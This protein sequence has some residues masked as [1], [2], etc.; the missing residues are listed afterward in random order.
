MPAI[1]I[2]G[3]LH[4]AE[5]RYA[6]QA[7]PSAGFDLPPHPKTVIA[8]ITSLDGPGGV[9]R[10]H[11]RTPADGP[12]YTKVTSRTHQ[13]L[14]DY[15]LA[16]MIAAVGFDKPAL[17]ALTPNLCDDEFEHY[18]ESGTPSV[19]AS[20]RTLAEAEE[21][22]RSGAVSREA[23]ESVGLDDHEGRMDAHGE[24]I[25]SI[26]ESDLEA[27]IDEHAMQVAF[28]LAIA[29]DSAAPPSGLDLSEPTYR[30]AVHRRDFADAAVKTA[31]RALDDDPTIEQINRLDAALGKVEAAEY[32][33]GLL[34]DPRVLDNLDPQRPGHLSVANTRAV[35]EHI[36]HTP[37]HG[38]GGGMLEP[39]LREN[40]I[41][42]LRAL[43]LTTF[44]K[45]SAETM[46]DSSSRHVART[47]GLAVGFGEAAEWLA[48][49]AEHSQQAGR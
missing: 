18:W 17:R 25:D 30:S 10:A 14:A 22:L 11:Q 1:D 45:A 19:D 28:D 26:A 47:E 21:S 49:E 3:A 36:H 44:T 4:D 42:H 37:P 34:N 39:R 35:Y 32:V 2:H 13:G 12:D 38:R 24:L 46:L 48:A 23:L 31:Q 27:Y 16:Q 29:N 40:A 5:G 20:L 41:R 43:S 33:T 15:P 7:K 8:D 6:D 9:D